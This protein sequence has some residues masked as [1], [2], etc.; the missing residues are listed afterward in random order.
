MLL[1]NLNVKNVLIMS[2]AIFNKNNLFYK[3]MRGVT[4]LWQ[5]P[6]I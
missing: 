2:I 6:N 4:V 3:F 1:M 5:K